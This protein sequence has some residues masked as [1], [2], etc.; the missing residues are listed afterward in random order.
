MHP[1]R[2]H[3]NHN[4]DLRQLEILI[5]NCNREQ[6]IQKRPLHPK[7]PDILKKI[8]EAKKWKEKKMQKRK[9]DLDKESNISVDE[10][11][12]KVDDELMSE[13]KSAHQQKEAQLIPEEKP[14]IE[15]EVSEE[16]D[17]EFEDL[18]IVEVKEP[19]ILSDQNTSIS[20]YRNIEQGEKAIYL[21]DA[22]E[23]ELQERGEKDLVLLEFDN[24]IFKS[25]LNPEKNTNQYLLSRNKILF[26]N[27]EEEEEPKID[28]EIL[29]SIYSKYSQSL[30]NLGLL[31][32]SDQ[33]LGYIF[34]QGLDSLV[35]DFVEEVIKQKDTA[36][37]NP[38][39]FLKVLD[40]KP[41]IDDADELDQL[42]C[43]FLNHSEEA[44][45]WFKTLLED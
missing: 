38:E 8:E 22:T 36:L 24:Y 29:R 13:I 33:F 45:G 9:I 19:I 39:G 28:L 34:D 43:N 27:E 23:E 16:D 1:R 11:A 26:F 10:R 21:R 31:E 14:L 17:F 32:Y 12:L 42:L 25:A 5:R 7:S 41:L 15:E 30:T 6:Q 4:R 2:K 35:Y 40:N 37:F 18:I 20:K 3:L 44:F